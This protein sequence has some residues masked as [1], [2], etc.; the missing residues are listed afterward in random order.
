MNDE[1]LRPGETDAPPD[2]A[3]AGVAPAPDRS[4]LYII[5]AL[6]FAAEE[7]LPPSRLAEIAAAVTPGGKTPSPDEIRAAVA[8]LNRCY[9]DSGRTFRLHRVAQG[10]QLYTLPEFARPV[11]LLYRRQLVQR[12]SRAALEVLAII[13]YRQPV[14]RPQVEEFRGVD[15]SGPLVTLLERRLIATAGKAHRPGSPYLYRTTREFLRYFGLES[16]DDLPPVEQLESFLAGAA[17]DSARQLEIETEQQ[18]AIGD[19][20]IIDAARAQEAALR[21][22]TDAPAGDGPAETPGPDAG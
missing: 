20:R 21:E 4:L 10:L 7:P 13:A 17:D 14:T 19:R 5:E 6:L 22:G 9:E 16:L 15:C 12:L 18:L 8:E 3:S 11:R 1:H 2:P